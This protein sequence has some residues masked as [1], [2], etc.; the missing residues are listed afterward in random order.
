LRAD[1]VD[2][3]LRKYAL[4]YE[5]ARRA[6]CARSRVEFEA[7]DDWYKRCD[8]IWDDAGFTMGLRLPS[9]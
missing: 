4:V 9:T 6:L 3:M 5:R 8:T 1:F 7:N 2:N